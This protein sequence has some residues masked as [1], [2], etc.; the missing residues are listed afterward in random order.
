[1]KSKKM[2]RFLNSLLSGLLLTLLLAAPALADVVTLVPNGDVSPGSWTPFAGPLLSDDVNAGGGGAGDATYATITATTDTFTV[3]MGNN[4]AYSGATIN[5]VRVYVRSAVFGGGGA[6]ERITF[7]STSPVT[8]TSGNVT[9]VD[10]TPTDAFFDL[11]GIAD[12]GAVDALEISVNTTN[13]GAGEDARIYDIW[14]DVTYTPLAAANELNACDS[15]HGQPP[16]EGASRNV[17][18]GAVVGS[19]AS[20]SAFA[21]TQCH[22]NN[23]VLNHRGGLGANG[24]EG[25]IGMLANISGGT[26]S[27][28]SAG[29]LQDNEDGTG[30][31]LCS[32]VTCH[33]GVDTPQWGDATGLDCAGCHGA[34]P[35]TNAHDTHYTAKSWGATDLAGTHCLECHPDNTSSHPLNGTPDVTL[36]PTGS[37]AA[38]SCGSAPAL[39]CHNGK[40]T[41]NWGTTNITCTQCHTAGGSDPADPTTGL[42]DETPVVS[43]VQHNPADPNF[44]AC[45]D[46]HTAAP[47][48]LHWDGI[49]QTSAPTINFDA[50]MTGFV[51]GTPP[52]CASTCHSES[53]TSGP[54]ARK[55]HENSDQ[56]GAASC[57][58]CHGDWTSGWNGGVTHRSDTGAGSTYTIHSTGTNYECQDCHALG[59]ASANTGYTYTEVTNDWGGTSN[60]GNGTITMNDSNT[61]WARSGGLSGCITC[62]PAFDGTDGAAGQNSFTQTGWNPDLVTGEVV[63]SGCDTCHGGGGDYWPKGGAYPDRAGEHDKHVTQLAAKLG[64][65]LPGSDAQQKQMCDYCHND[66]LGAGGIGHDDNVSPSDVGGFNRLWD[67]AA[68]GTSSYTAGNQTCAIACH[69]GK[70]TAAGTYGWN[71]AGTSLCTMCHTA[72]G[73]VANEI[74]NPTTG[75]HDATA[76]VTSTPHDQDLDPS[77]CVIC[78]T[79]TPSSAHID[80]NPDNSWPTITIAGSSGFSDGGTPTCAN[81]CHLDGGAWDRLW[82]ENSEQSDGTECAGCHGTFQTGF[83]NGVSLRHQTSTSG[84]PGGQILANHGNTDP[85]L[86]CHTY[87]GADTYGHKWG[88]HHLDTKIQ[89]SDQVSFSDDGATVSC[90]A[91]HTTPYGTG[92]GS[93]SF[94]DTTQTTG[95]TRQIVAGPTASCTGCHSSQAAGA[96]GVGPDSPHSN[97][98]A[99]GG[100]VYDCE[101]CHTSHT[102]GN[103]QVP[104]N[105]AVGIDYQNGV[106]GYSGFNGLNL[107]GTQS[108][109]ATEADICWNCHDLNATSEW[110]KTWGAYDT[111]NMSGSDWTTSTW[112]SVNFAY[113]TDGTDG[114]DGNIRSTH[115]NGSSGGTGGYGVD[116]KN[117]IGCSYCH[118]VHDTKAGSPNGAPYL[119]GLWTSNPFKEDGAPQTAAHASNSAHGGVPR[120]GLDSGYA[121]ATPNALGGWQIEQNNPGAYTRT[122][123]YTGHSELCS[124]CHLDT[125]LEAAWSGHAAAVD[126]FSGTGASDIFNSFR[127]GG[128]TSY[129]RA[130]MQHNEVTDTENGNW[131]YGLRES[132]DG[133]GIAPQL[134]SDPTLPNVQRGGAWT[135]MTIDLTDSS[136]TPD[137]DFHQ[138]S[139][140]KCHN[141]HASRLPRLMITNCLDVRHNHWDDS[142]GDPSALI[143]PLDTYTAKELAYS[144]TAVNCHR[145]V[146]GGDA[147]RETNAGAETGWNTQTPW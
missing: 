6:G 62:H 11:V 17:T 72:G 110:G 83:N 66:G 77:G 46:C 78:H 129:L 131:V 24:T 107:G 30:L 135:S 2:T 95:W 137:A 123:T 63:V 19:H 125:D 51:D 36:T 116:A 97:D 108:P 52:T 64:F 25:Q 106:N 58:G 117:K 113:K 49:A 48:D 74:I 102:G 31:G 10:N 133:D 38:L 93:H 70:T 43:G 144:P 84:D 28:G 121:G 35:A 9:L 29:F 126:G 104:N 23:A 12:S 20:H 140:S 61:A 14:V 118:D 90:T 105:A 55:W 103:V 114:G 128:T 143:D 21:C 138:F 45:D 132:R 85:C 27:L 146:G 100:G 115:G 89:I 91:C 96:A 111:G 26:Y 88:T 41:P 50:G 15:C 39:G 4:A 136:E 79:A 33:S 122:G 139:C 8:S 40:Q 60:H 112:S 109:G 134:P 81:V 59:K 124:L 76:N 101:G 127:R 53:G 130:H 98:T 1:M 145:N 42:H 47:S 16:V 56:A 54:W 7:G 13:L 34:P 142:E 5:S 80:G 87:D 65:A 94:T 71:D 141:P 147:N 44:S 99:A 3:S 86:T 18:E 69:N 22:P 32:N 119:R 68:D 37:G 57:V 67:A 92:D 75:L 82:H 73:G 120:A